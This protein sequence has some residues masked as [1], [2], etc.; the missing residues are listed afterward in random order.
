MV[1]VGF[2][3]GG[4]TF[5]IRFRCYTSKGG[6][7]NYPT[8]DATSLLGPPVIRNSQATRS[9]KLPLYT[10][11]C[12]HPRIRKQLLQKNAILQN[13]SSATAVQTYAALK[14]RRTAVTKVACTSSL[15]PNRCRTTAPTRTGTTASA[16]MARTTTTSTTSTTALPT[17]TATTA[18]TAATVTPTYYFCEHHDQQHLVFA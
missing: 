12:N 8:F 18:D 15:P 10:C 17:T 14:K 2:K 16:L 3:G 5:K 6:Y 1:F 4:K 7:I 13:Y 9:T 11:A